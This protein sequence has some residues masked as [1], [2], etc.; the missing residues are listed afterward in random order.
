ML[1][2]HQMIVN[3]LRF[4]TYIWFVCLF[5]F[6]FS[7]CVRARVHMCVFFLIKIFTKFVGWVDDIF[8]SDINSIKTNMLAWVSQMQRLGL[9][10]TTGSTTIFCIILW[11]RHFSPLNLLRCMFWENFD[12]GWCHRFKGLEI[13]QRICHYLIVFLFTHGLPN[14]HFIVVKIWTT[15]RLWSIQE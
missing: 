5:C 10:K 9:Y 14:G 4:Y 8:M 11:V 6:V 13:G 2:S 3:A 1:V 7:W 15:M 12:I